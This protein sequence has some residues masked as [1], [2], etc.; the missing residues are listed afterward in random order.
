LGF[1]AT[2]TTVAMNQS[3][4]AISPD[5]AANMN[6]TSLAVGARIPYHLLVLE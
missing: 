6:N 3:P 2:F 4:A 1:L 5:A